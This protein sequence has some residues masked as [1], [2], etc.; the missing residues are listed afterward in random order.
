M[1]QKQKI[2]KKTR[3]RKKSKIN[4]WQKYLKPEKGIFFFLK[5]VIRLFYVPGFKFQDRI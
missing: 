2:K 3:N 1:R 5:K 4:N